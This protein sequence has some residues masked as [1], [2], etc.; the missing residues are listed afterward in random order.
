MKTKHTKW[1]V[2]ESPANITKESRLP[3]NPIYYKNVKDQKSIG[4]RIIAKCLGKTIKEVEAH[5]KLIAVVPE[6]LET[7]IDEIKYLKEMKRY[8]ELPDKRG[9]CVY[10]YN[11]L[12][13]F[14][15][16]IKKATES[17]ALITYD[18]C[19]KSQS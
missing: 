4:G 6:L 15:K 2:S 13:D 3:F 1:A 16:L 18:D 5:A 17:E 19:M 10:N 11:R 14:E 12:E 8:N 7:L 9:E